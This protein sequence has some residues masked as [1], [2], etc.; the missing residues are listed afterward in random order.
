MILS[1]KIEKEK[2]KSNSLIKANKVNGLNKDSI[3]KTAQS[4][5]LR[6]E[7]IV[8]K[9]WEVPYKDIELYKSLR[10]VIPN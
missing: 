1:S 8:D 4:Y 7:N 10:E 6:S 9:I 2:C 5:L 3:V